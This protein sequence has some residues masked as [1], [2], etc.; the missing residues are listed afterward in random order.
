[1]AHF[2][3]SRIPP[4]EILP[5]NSLKKQHFFYLKQLPVYMKLPQR[6]I[7]FFFSVLHR[8]KPR[9][10]SGRNGPAFQVSTE[11]RAGQVSR[12]RSGRLSR[13]YAMESL[14]VWMRPGV[15]GCS[16]TYPTAV[17]GNGGDCKVCKG[18]L[19]QNEP[20]FRF[21]IYSHIVICPESLLE[22]LVNKHSCKICSKSRADVQM[23][24]FT[25]T[26]TIGWFS[27]LW[28]FLGVSGR[29]Y[30]HLKTNHKELQLI[31]VELYLILSPQCSGWSAKM[32]SHS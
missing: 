14:E 13:E 10:A 27:V 25:Y 7:A 1:M 17:V 31:V 6:I 3:H 30:G 19:K 28:K 12:E 2:H 18:N 26:V 9:A 24:V 4:K 20:S 32:A 22:I 23:H 16:G 21:R 15:V 8:K 11:F 5:L 29:V